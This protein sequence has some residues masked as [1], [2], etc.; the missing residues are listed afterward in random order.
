VKASLALALL[1]LGLAGWAVL[2]PFDAAPERTTRATGPADGELV[3]NLNERL[4]AL[5]A[6]NLRLSGRLAALEAQPRAAEPARVPAGTPAPDPELDSEPELGLVSISE[7][8][9]VLRRALE[10]D[11]G[12]LEERV[13][14]TIAKVR[15]DEQAAKVQAHHEKRLARLDADVERFT[16]KLELDTHQAQQLRAALLA[17][18]DRD[19]ALTQLWEQGVADDVLGEQKQADGAAFSEDL[20]AFLSDD[21][22]DTFWNAAHGK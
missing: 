5:E 21:Q 1:A 3:L 9:A 12:L 19:A 22:L 8:D 13:A 15:K 17:Q 6:E 11:G 16:E 18:Y 10:S 20:G 2:R 4:A 14:Q 7:A